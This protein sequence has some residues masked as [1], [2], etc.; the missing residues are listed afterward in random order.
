[1][2]RKIAIRKILIAAAWLAVGTG[3]SVLLVAANREQKERHCK[4]VVVQVGGEG[5]RMV[6]EKEDVMQQLKKATNGT[7]INK[8]VDQI[9]LVALERS[10]EKHPWVKDARLYFDSRDVLHVSVK[11]RQPVARVFTTAGSSFYLDSSGKRMPLDKVAVRV[12]VVSN[13]PAA[14]KLNKGDSVLLND[15]KSLIT[16]ISANEFWKAQISQ[17]DIT[18]SGTFELVPVIGNHIIRIGTADDLEAKLQRLFLYYK[19]VA[20]KAGFDKYPI[21]DV[22]YAGQVIGVKDRFASPVDSIQLQKNIQALI[23]RS[24]QLAWQDSIAIV[25]QFNA[26][27]RRDSTIKDLLNTLE[28]KAKEEEKELVPEKI[29]VQPS[30]PEKNPATA[31]IK[32]PLKTKSTPVKTTPQSKPVEKQKPKAVMK[33][34]E[35]T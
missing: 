4:E 23:D 3:M 17:I 18:S 1:M 2:K 7:L 10:L 32:A 21:L 22:Q 16:Y 35:N 19:Q 9:N 31:P 5:A 26:Q 15:V 28:E 33:K 20:T 8:P 27:V 13:F 6:I 25:E 30:A 12:P 11:E 34:K 29:I 24:K 14:R